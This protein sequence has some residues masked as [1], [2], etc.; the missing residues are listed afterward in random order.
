MHLLRKGVNCGT[1]RKGGDILPVHGIA[2]LE[3]LEH[4]D[5][6]PTC[7]TV[8]GYRSDD[9]DGHS[10]VCLRIDGFDNLAKG[11]LAE[12]TNSAI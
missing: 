7:I 9:L 10:C 6:N 11:P 8:F 2:F 4:T 3:L 1:R 5:F 12:E